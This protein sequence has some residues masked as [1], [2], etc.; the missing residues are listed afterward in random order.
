MILLL[1][2]FKHY[3]QS[4]PPFKLQ[5]TTALIL[6]YNIV[7]RYICYYVMYVQII[8][9]INEYFA[10]WLILLGYCKS[11][12][13]SGLALQT[14][15]GCPPA[16]HSLLQHA[17]SIPDIRRRLQDATSYFAKPVK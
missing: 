6:D 3:L 4:F 11:G 14:P 9:S 7:T 12:E 8:R 13:C 5:T 10:K 15:G 16:A 2:L 17:G 1:Y